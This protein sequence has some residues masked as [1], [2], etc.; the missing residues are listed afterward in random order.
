MSATISTSIS[1]QHVQHAHDDGSPARATL[2]QTASTTESDVGV[3]GFRYIR[4]LGRGNSGR[5]MLA[6][7]STSATLF[8][9]KVIDKTTLLSNNSLGTIKTERLALTTLAREHH[10]FVIELLYCFETASRFYFVTEFASGGDLLYHLHRQSFAPSRAKFYAAEVL[11]ALDHLHR[12]G[13]LYRHLSL[14]NVMLANDGHI[15]LIDFE[16][17]KMNMW[18]GQRTSTFCG[19]SEFMAPELIMGQ[20]YGRGAEWWSFGILSFQMLTGRS[21]FQ[22]DDED[23]IC[24]SILRDD[25][26]HLDTLPAEAE[27]LIHGLLQRDPSER[28]GSGP[29]DAE[30]IKAQPFF[31]EIIWSDLMN[32]RVDP[33]FVPVLAS[34]CDT[35]YFDEEFTSQTPRLAPPVACLPNGNDRHIDDFDWS[36]PDVRTTS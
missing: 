36:H 28:L 29:S 26:S 11:S 1:G 20:S 31:A 30:E 4:M 33:P 19:T 8:A 2:S 13:I 16:L 18:H 3:N 17:C 7:N 27:M 6:E 9:I 10:P 23:E 5:V 12:L 14:D 15:K 21:P 24:Q 25:P 22:G 32:K 34:Q 35:R